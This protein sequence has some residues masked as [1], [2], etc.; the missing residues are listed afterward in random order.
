MASNGRLKVLPM[1]KD[2]EQYA[3]LTITGDFDPEAITAAL[4][5]QSSEA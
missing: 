5:L 4:G 3:Y 1:T 2:N